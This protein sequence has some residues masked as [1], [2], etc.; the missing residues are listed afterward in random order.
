MYCDMSVCVSAR[1][2]SKTTEPNFTKCSVH[3]ICGC[4][5]VLLQFNMLCTYVFVDDITFSHYGAY[6]VAQWQWS[7]MSDP[8]LPCLSNIDLTAAD[9]KL[10]D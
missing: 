10:F 5:S 6:T 1:Y 3:V 4:G 8:S 9:S 2:I 7:L